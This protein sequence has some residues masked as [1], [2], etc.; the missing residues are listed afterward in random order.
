MDT[1]RQALEV[2]EE[3]GSTPFI[4]GGEPTV[5]PE[6]ETILLESIAYAGD[7]CEGSVGIVTNGK[8]KKRAMMLVS[9]A[10]GGVITAELSRDQYH[11]P[12]DYSVVKAFESL[13]GTARWKYGVRDTSDG[14]RRE[15]LPHGRAKTEVLGWDEEDRHDDSRD[16][17]D[18]PC[19][20]WVVKPNGDIHQCGCDDSPKVGSL[21]EGIE[22]PL[23]NA[24][25]RSHEWMYECCENDVEHLIYG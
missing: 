12:I 1:F 4:G 5:H 15:P 6:F 9:L 21:S 18:C 25:C 19:E 20:Q 17:G 7:I 24:C 22:S 16:D 2:C 3:Y 13:G 10:K 14:G 11:E 8:L 23:N